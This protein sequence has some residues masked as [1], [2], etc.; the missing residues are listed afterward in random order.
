MKQPMHCPG[1]SSYNFILGTLV[2]FIKHNQNYY[3][4]L[5]V[6]TSIRGLHQKKLVYH[7]S[8]SAAFCRHTWRLL[9]IIIIIIIIIIS[10]YSVAFG[11][12][13]SLLFF[14]VCLYG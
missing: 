10:P 2:N 8:A 6:S 9:I 14:F 1:I 11:V 7:T 4:K 3:L 13:L 5:D 12:I